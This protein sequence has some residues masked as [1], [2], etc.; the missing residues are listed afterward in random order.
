MS[1]N[2]VGSRTLPIPSKGGVSMATEAEARAT[3]KL[4]LFLSAC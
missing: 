2:G 3:L 1:H 4:V